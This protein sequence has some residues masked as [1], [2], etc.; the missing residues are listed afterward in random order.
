MFPKSN[1]E[2]LM[3]EH[4]LNWL[5]QQARTQT[6]TKFNLAI[7]AP[8]GPPSPYIRRKLLE[9]ASSS[10]GVRLKLVKGQ[11][12]N[13]RAATCRAEHPVHA[14]VSVRHYGNFV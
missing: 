9:R 6:I 7:K 1:N 12:N 10:Q 13:N 14:G 3:G 5:I 2:K 4:K 8:I 11:K